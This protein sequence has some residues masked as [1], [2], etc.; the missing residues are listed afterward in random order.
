M[1]YTFELIASQSK[2]MSFFSRTFELI[3]RCKERE[4]ERE[5][6]KTYNFLQSLFR[7]S[8]FLNLCRANILNDDHFETKL[9][10]DIIVSIRT[11]RYPSTYTSWR[12]F[13]ATQ[14]HIS[15]YQK[16]AVPAILTHTSL[17]HARTYT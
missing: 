3:A 1:F 15:N 9:C 16:S 2:L 12:E 6:K 13:I 8:R 14:E 10:T 5:K 17:T 7:L 11:S 4:R